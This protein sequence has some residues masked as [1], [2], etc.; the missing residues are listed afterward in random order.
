MAAAKPMTKS[1]LISEIADKLNVTK[2][3][4]MV[5]LIRWAQLLTRKLKRP[6]LLCCLDSG[7]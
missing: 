1:Q 7:N 6:V 3:M 2:K 4:Q 5:F